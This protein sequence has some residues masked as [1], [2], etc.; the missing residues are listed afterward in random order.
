MAAGALIG[1]GNYDFIIYHSIVSK[2]I[3]KL[4][5]YKAFRPKP[6]DDTAKSSQVHSF[7]CLQQMDRILPK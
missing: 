5:D 3:S 2:S 6:K 4:L 7:I 1:A